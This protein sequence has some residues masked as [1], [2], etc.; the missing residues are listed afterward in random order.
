M[1]NL[2]HVQRGDPLRIPANDWNAIVDATRAHLEKQ[3]AG[4]NQPARVIEQR[5]AGVIFVRNDSGGDRER[6]GSEFY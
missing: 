4:G 6:F 5:N 3:F 2:K 1:A